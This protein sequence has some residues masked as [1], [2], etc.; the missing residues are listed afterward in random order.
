M[1][2]GHHAYAFRQEM[3]LEWC[4]EVVYSHVSRGSWQQPLHP[5]A[6][7]SPAAALREPS[8]S[9]CFDRIYTHLV[10]LMEKTQMSNLCHSLG[11][12]LSSCIT[13]CPRL[14]GPHT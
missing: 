5:F 1:T 10:L 12:S 13:E 4:V 3:A 7:T 2:S 9:Y 6:S 8:N 11:P 14:S